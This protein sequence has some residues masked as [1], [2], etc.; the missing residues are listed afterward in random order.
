MSVCRGNFAFVLQESSSDPAALGRSWS[1]AA[2]PRAAPAPS[3]GDTGCTGMAWF[4]GF[5]SFISVTHRKKLIPFLERAGVKPHMVSR[6]G[7]KISGL[8]T[9]PDAS[10]HDSV[11]VVKSC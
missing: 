7:P 5:V 8:V 1:T 2:D 4:A 9:D 3:D 6:N 10:R 11:I